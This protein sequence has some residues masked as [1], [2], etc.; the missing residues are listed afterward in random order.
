MQIQRSFRE[1]S[2]VT[3]IL[4]PGFYE[5]ELIGDLKGFLAGITKLDLNA[6]ELGGGVGLSFEKQPGA[7]AVFVSESGVH[8]GLVFEKG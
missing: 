5:A 8:Q 6:V 7:L 1:P 2:G 3:R 4:S